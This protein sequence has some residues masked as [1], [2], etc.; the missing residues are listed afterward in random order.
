MVEKE[1][2]AGMVQLHRRIIRDQ[3]FW[4]S[5]SILCGRDVYEGLNC[6]KSVDLTK[7]LPGLCQG[8]V[9]LPA[10]LYGH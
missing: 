2:K 8:K 5:K 7:S 9:S 10:K 1:K 6:T 4:M 3:Y